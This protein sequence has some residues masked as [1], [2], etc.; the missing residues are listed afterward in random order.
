MVEKIADPLTHL[1]RSMDHDKLQRCA[2]NARQ[3]RAWR[4]RSTRTTTPALVIEVS[5]DG[6]GLSRDRIRLA[7]AVE[8]GLVEPDEAAQLDPEIYG[9]IFE[10]GFSTSRADDEPVGPRRRDGR[11]QAQHHRAARRGR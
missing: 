10:P 8:R 11:G 2:P 7:K 1:V 6:G 4:G 9:L 3:A 5:D